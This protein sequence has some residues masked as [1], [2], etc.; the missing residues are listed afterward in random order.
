MN[1]TQLQ[2]IDFN[3]V[4]NYVRSGDLSFYNFY[5]ADI[6]IGTH[7]TVDYYLN[8]PNDTMDV[9]QVVNTSFTDIELYN[10]NDEDFEFKAAHLPINAITIMDSVS[11][12]YHSYYL[13]QEFNM[14]LFGIKRTADF[15]YPAFIKGIQEQIKTILV[16]DKYFD[17][18]CDLTVYIYSQE[19]DLLRDYWA[20][21]MTIDPCIISGWNSDYFD[22]PYLYSRTVKLH[23]ADAA[24]KMITKLG[25]VTV[26][27][28]L[29]SIPEYTNLDLLY[30]YKPRDEGGLNLGK[31]QSQ[32]T[33]DNIST[34]ELGLKKIEYKSENVSLNDLYEK[35][36]FWF[37]VYNVVDVALTYLLNRK[38]KH[39]DLYNTI[40]RIMRS[41][42][43]AS[44]MGS[45]VIFDSKIYSELVDRGQYVRYGISSELRRTL[46]E[47]HL[48]N[49]PKLNDP[50]GKVCKIPKIPSKTYGNTLTRFP[51][52]YVKLPTQK[53]I[54]D[55]SL[56]IDL[57]AK[58][59]YPSMILQS[60]ISFDSY[61]ARILPA[62]TYKTLQLLENTLGKTIMPDALSQNVANMVWEYAKTVK[63]QK[64]DSAI[65]MYNIILYLFMKLFSSG[66]T[67]QQMM[68]PST[69]KE[70]VYLRHY[71]IPLLDGLNLI[72]P[73]NLKYSQFVYDYLFMDRYDANNVDLL[74][75]KYPEIY[76]LFNPADANAYIQKFP[77]VEGVKEFQKYAI[78]LAGTLFTRHA[79]Y[80]GLFTNFLINMGNLRGQYKDARQLCERGSDE[81]ILNDN[82]QKSFKVVMN[83]TYGLYGLSTFR[84]SNHWLAQSITNNG[85]LTIKIA[86]QLG[87]DYLNYKYGN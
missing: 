75:H 2:Q 42:Y 31:K 20:R 77:L 84:Y 22:F 38:L 73:E 9:D 33:L 57:D 56:V 83:T 36:P 28:D 64:R 76:I 5:N 44:I 66:L 55:G 10:P 25:H 58:A 23:G 62:C 51:G 69:F 35:D 40:R 32:Y 19:E 53:I 81:Y 47:R 63:A 17:E 70:H 26:K 30:A 79:E 45:S 78:T 49:L 14:E 86:Q 41:G 4:L 37:L 65:R 82:R 43:N 39:I 71:L 61:V 50:K 13:L 74:Q 29:I 48:S 67:F 60:N 18:G 46:D 6:P 80:T 68:T 12:H 72:H 11:K 87:E 1:N 34:V 54:N 27:G 7:Y 3:Q 15:D 24:N 85:M 59:L 21:L 16:K 52:A 8:H